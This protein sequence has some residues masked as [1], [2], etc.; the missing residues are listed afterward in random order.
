MTHGDTGVSSK[1]SGSDDREIIVQKGIWGRITGQNKAI[2]CWVNPFCRKSTEDPK[3][4][5]VIPNKNMRQSDSPGLPT[6][7]ECEKGGGDEHARMGWYTLIRKKSNYPTK[8]VGGR[9]KS[10]T[11]VGKLKTSVTRVRDQEEMPP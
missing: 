5:S 2:C 9:S 10:G 11:L 4:G 8:P 6:G 7:T 1:A 3:A